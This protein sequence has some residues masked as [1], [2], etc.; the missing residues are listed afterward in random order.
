[1]ICQSDGY[2]YDK[3]FFVRRIPGIQNKERVEL[4]GKTNSRPAGEHGW[5]GLEP[6]CFSV[7][8]NNCHPVVFGREHK[9]LPGKI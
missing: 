7:P 5:F 4:A 8:F 1:M 6:G 3:C 2:R 9:V